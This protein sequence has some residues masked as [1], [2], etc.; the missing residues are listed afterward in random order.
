M[1]MFV[2]LLSRKVNLAA[3]GKATKGFLDFRL[4]LSIYCKENLTYPRPTFSRELAPGAWSQWVHS[5]ALSISILQDEED[6]G[7]ATVVV[8]VPA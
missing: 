4:A 8:V 1:D 7:V 6:C 2:A 5:E 3:G